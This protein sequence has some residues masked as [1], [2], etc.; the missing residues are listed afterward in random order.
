MDE[1]KKVQQPQNKNSGGIKSAWYVWLLL[2]VLLSAGAYFA[3]TQ[4]GLL[5]TGEEIT[6]PT[7]TPSPTPTKEVISQFNTKYYKYKLF[8]NTTGKDWD[9]EL[10]RVHRK[11]FKEETVVAS[12][13]EAVPALKERFNLFLA[14]FAQPDNSDKIFFHV[15][16]MDTDAPPGD[17]YVYDIKENKFE[18]LKKANEI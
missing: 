8:D 10:I 17:L 3:L 16:L 6:T 7:P 4:F 2:G 18:K 13:K 5:N 1:E 9:Q 15:V 11:T 14:D 12:I